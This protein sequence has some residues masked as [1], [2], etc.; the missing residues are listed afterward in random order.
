MSFHDLVIVLV[1]MFPMLIFTVFAGIKLSE[2][3]YKHHNITET[4]KRAV[5]M[6]VTFIFAFVLSLAV[7]YL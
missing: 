2:Y 7:H 5:M 6:S 4:Q 3:L 1:M